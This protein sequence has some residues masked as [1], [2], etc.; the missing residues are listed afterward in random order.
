MRVTNE[1]A[2]LRILDENQ[3]ARLSNYT[4]EVTSMT[5]ASV[6]ILHHLM[7]KTWTLQTKA[8]G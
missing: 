5:R 6:S 1:T 7:G 8:A 3:E 2:V 4:D